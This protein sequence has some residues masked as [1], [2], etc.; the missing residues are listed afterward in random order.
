MNRLYRQFGKRAFDLA[1]SVPTT[2]VLSPVITMVAFLVRLKLGS[3]VVF[4]QARASYKGRPFTVYKFRTMR[5]TRDE[6]GNLLPDEDRLTRFGDILRKLSLDELPQLWNVIR[7]DMS[8]VGPRPLMTRY[9]ERYSPEQARRHDVT[10][11]VTGWAQVNG[12]NTISWE[13]KFELDVWY[14][15]HLGF[16]LDLKIL[17]LTV[18]QV[19]SRKDIHADGCV[20]MSEFMGTKSSQRAGRQE[21]RRDTP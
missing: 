20:T 9:L 21:M 6:A 15:D 12:R 1:L 8:L 13:E 5:N 18:V 2:I 16:F 11:G 19:F 17:W 14:V 7:G 3:P 10:T 4:R